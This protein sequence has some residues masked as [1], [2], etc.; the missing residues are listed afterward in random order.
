MSQGSLT[1]QQ[2][3][4][5]GGGDNNSDMII[6]SPPIFHHSHHHRGGKSHSHSRNIELLVLLLIVLKLFDVSTWSV[7]LQQVKNL[8]VCNVLINSITSSSLPSLQNLKV[9]YENT[10]WAKIAASCFCHGKN[11]SHPSSK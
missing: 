11:I 9:P 2:Q 6:Y 1:R 10:F 4:G 8:S 3:G 5:H 7:V